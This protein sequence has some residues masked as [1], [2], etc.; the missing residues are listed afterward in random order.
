MTTIRRSLTAAFAAVASL[1]LAGCV[2]PV[3]GGGIVVTPPSAAINP[4]GTWCFEDRRGRQRVHLIDAYRGG[5]DV[6]PARNPDRR[7]EFVRVSTRQY[8]E[9]DG[10][11][12][13]WFRGDGTALWSRDGSRDRAFEAYRCR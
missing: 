5:M 13:Y 10:P 9:L 11:G 7:R 2:E 8:N 4:S 12:V 6:A 1:I 3:P